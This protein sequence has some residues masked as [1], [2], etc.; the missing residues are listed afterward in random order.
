MLVDLQLQIDLFISFIKALVLVFL[1]FCFYFPTFLLSKVNDHTLIYKCNVLYNV[2]FKASSDT[3]ILE[4]CLI[5]KKSLIQEN[6]F[7]FLTITFI[8]ITANPNF[9]VFRWEC[10]SIMKNNF[11]TASFVIHNPPQFN[12]L[13][14]IVFRFT[15]TSLLQAYLNGRPC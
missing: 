5:L 13:I 3:G 7:S 2:S 1:I 11:S 6:D 9:C 14:N 8:S 12:A 4:E 15:S 10:F